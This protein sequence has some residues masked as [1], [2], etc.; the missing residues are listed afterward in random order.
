MTGG[1]GLGVAVGD[2]E[3]V[4]VG[5]GVGAGAGGGVVPPPPPLLLKVQAGP[6]LAPSGW[7][8]TTKRRPLNALLKGPGP[9]SWPPK[10]LRGARQQGGMAVVKPCRKSAC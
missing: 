3:R 6:L 10:P 5:V 9:P 4:G 8:H 2:G 7:S 1:R